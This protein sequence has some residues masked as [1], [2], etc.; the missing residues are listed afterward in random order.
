VKKTGIEETPV[1]AG[2]ESLDSNTQR[3][4]REKQSSISSGRG[5]NKELG[6]FNVLGVEQSPSGM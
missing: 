2:V 1:H 5:G 3:N 4:V 6:K